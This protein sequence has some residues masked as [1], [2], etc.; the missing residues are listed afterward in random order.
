MNAKRSSPEA[1]RAELFATRCELLN[2]GGVNHVRNDG[3]R[4]WELEPKLLAG[5]VRA[6][7]DGAGN[8]RIHEDGRGLRVETVGP[9]SGCDEESDEPCEP[10][11]P[12]ELV[13]PP[14]LNGGG[15]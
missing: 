5:Y 2:S 6:T 11:A 8:V 14:Q 7:L 10:V 15:R 3:E 9:R 1:Q 13:F 12:T 4:R